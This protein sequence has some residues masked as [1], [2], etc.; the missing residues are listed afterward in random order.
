VDAIS[1]KRVQLE[2]KPRKSGDDDISRQWRVAVQIPPQMIGLAAA[3]AGRLD[4][5]GVREKVRISP[6][7]L[8]ETANNPSCCLDE[9]TVEK[10]KPD[11]VIHCGIACQTHRLNQTRCGTPL[12]HDDGWLPLDPTKLVSAVRGTLTSLLTPPSLPSGKKNNVP[13]EGDEAEVLFVLDAPYE[14]AKVGC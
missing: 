11:V 6:I 14:W 1:R 12:L 10:V 5:P 7:I 4:R 13:K 9:L 8:C 3:I 2:R